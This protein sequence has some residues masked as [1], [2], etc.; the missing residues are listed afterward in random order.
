MTYCSQSIGGRVHSKEPNCKSI[1]LRKVFP[2]EVQNIISFKKHENVGPDGKAKYPLPKEGQPINLP[3]PLGGTSNSDSEDRPKPPVTKYWDEGWY[4]WTGQ[5]RWSF[6]QKTETMMQDFQGQKQIELKLESRREVWHEYQEH[7]KRG[8]GGVADEQSKF[9]G[10][11]VPPMPMPNT[12]YVPELLR[13]ALHLDNFI[14][15]LVLSHCWFLYR[16]IYQSLRKSINFLNQLIKFWTS[17][18][19]ASRLESRG[20]LLN[21]YGKNS[22]RTSL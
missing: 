19:R 12:S 13:I 18:M 8:V 9:W 15:P 5:G 6:L 3:R 14:D 22:S 10:P 2:H 17:C 21:G 4:L 7:L 1:C 16:L 11:I 20:S